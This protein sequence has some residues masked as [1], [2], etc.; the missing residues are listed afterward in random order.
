[1][2]YQE[3]IC[4]AFEGV[5]LFQ[6]FIAFPLDDENIQLKKTCLFDRDCE[7]NIWLHLRC[8]TRKNADNNNT[9]KLFHFIESNL[10]KTFVMGRRINFVSYKSFCENCLSVGDLQTVG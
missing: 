4:I 8:L 3:N 5:L 7:P 6:G 9:Q 1:M 10:T 2:L